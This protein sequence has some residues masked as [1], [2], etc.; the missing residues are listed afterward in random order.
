MVYIINDLTQH[1]DIGF[2]L[3]QCFGTIKAKTEVTTRDAIVLPFKAQMKQSIE[4]IEC[5]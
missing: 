2:S 5:F 3:L 1:L 4:E